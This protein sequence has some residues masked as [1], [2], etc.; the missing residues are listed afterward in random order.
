MSSLHVTLPARLA[1]SACPSCVMFCLQL[2]ST[3]VYVCCS[4]LNAYQRTDTVSDTRVQI[5]KTM[6]VLV[7]IAIFF[8]LLMHLLGVSV[9]GGIGVEMLTPV[10]LDFIRYVTREI[11][12]LMS[13]F[14]YFCFFYSQRLRGHQWPNVYV[15]RPGWFTVH[16]KGMWHGLIRTSEHN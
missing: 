11:T 10:V 13:H 12:T 2:G 16:H 1:C 3:M 14:S 7:A 9:L 6:N 5:T 15:V 4:L 8:T